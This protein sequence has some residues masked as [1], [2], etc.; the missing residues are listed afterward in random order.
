ML[1]QVG[2]LAQLLREYDAYQLDILGVSEMRWTGSGRM[3]NDG[4]TIM[5]TKNNMYVA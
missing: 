4:R 3:H 2:K 5:V 1:Y